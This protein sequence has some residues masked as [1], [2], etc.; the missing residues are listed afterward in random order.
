M[1]RHYKSKLQKNIEDVWQN[2][3]T[4]RHAKVHIESMPKRIT[5]II[6]G[7]DGITKY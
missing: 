4:I 7:K 3:P 1:K 6:K 2:H 5:Q